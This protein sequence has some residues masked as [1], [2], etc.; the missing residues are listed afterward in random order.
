MLETNEVTI[1]RI[2]NPTSID[3]GEY[4]INPYKGCEFSCMYCYVKSNKVTGKIQKPWGT[5]VDIRI[6]APDLLEKELA[7]KKP[8]TVLL[9]STTECFQPVEKEFQLTRKL[10][11][12]LNKNKVSYVILTRSPCIVDYISLLNQGFC[13]KIYFTVNN[14]NHSFKQVLEP[15][16][17]AFPSRNKAIHTLLNEG[18]TVIPYYSPVMP[19]TTD[20]REVFSTFTKAER[21][22][23]EYLNFS[24]KNINEI[25]ENIFLVDP[26]LK[27]QLIAMTCDK[28]FYEQVWK[29][30]DIEIEKQ[31]KKARKEYKIYKHNFGEFFKNSYNAKISGIEEKTKIH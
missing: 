19:W 27:E 5:Y 15:K 1:N 3:L 21:I 8:R 31:A 14:F 2:L 30:L 18:I 16:S 4:V 23:F 22:E 17:P 12:I 11:E 26:F 7:I 6:N 28:D 24:L 10:L 29:A 9:G 25:L 20:I 13:R